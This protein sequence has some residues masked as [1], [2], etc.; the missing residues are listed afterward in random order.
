MITKGQIPSI[1]IM[2]YSLFRLGAAGHY[3]DIEDLFLFAYKL[4]PETFSWRTYGFPCSTSFRVHYAD[5]KAV[6]RALCSEARI[7]A[8]DNS[9]P[10]VW[11]GPE[12]DL[13]TSNL[14]WEGRGH[15]CQ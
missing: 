5:S 13:L 11:A 3:V 9:P 6:I 10:K 14:F 1:N 8:L 12:S 15:A 4:A 2:P 7:N